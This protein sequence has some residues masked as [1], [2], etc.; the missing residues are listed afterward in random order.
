V[1]KYYR[2]TLTIDIFSE[3]PLEEGTLDDLSDLIYS[4]FDAEHAVVINTVNDNQEVPA[5]ALPAV[6]ESLGHLDLSA[7]W[8]ENDLGTLLRKEQEEEDA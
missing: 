4:A 6:L 5:A 7:D 8:R 1:T 3:V 2:N